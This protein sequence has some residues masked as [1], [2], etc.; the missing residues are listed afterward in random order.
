MAG[1]LQLLKPNHDRELRIPN[2]E[3]RIPNGELR[4][5]N[6]ELR[7]PKSLLTDSTFFCSA[8]TPGNPCFNCPAVLL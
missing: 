1:K 5:P 4:I 6:G 7:I 3:L 8:R 2:G